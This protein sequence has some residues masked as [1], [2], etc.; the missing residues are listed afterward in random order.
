MYVRILRVVIHSTT[1]ALHFQ[2]SK[3]RSCLLVL[4]H[5]L[6]HHWVRTSSPRPRLHPHQHNHHVSGV[7]GA[8]DASGVAGPR[9][10]SICCPRVESTHDSIFIDYD[11]LSGDRWL[12]EVGVSSRKY[13]TAS[14]AAAR[15]AVAVDPKGTHG[16]ARWTLGIPVPHFISRTCVRT[17][18]IMARIA[19]HRDSQN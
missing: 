16:R 3:F 10:L 19:F 11:V 13:A 5:H 2:R 17:L 14:G 1:R 7:D 4:R 9:V 15:S 12:L 18:E 8:V 6:C